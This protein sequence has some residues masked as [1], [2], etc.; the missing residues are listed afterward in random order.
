MQTNCQQCTF[1]PRVS[2]VLLAQGSVSL[3]SNE[4]PNPPHNSASTILAAAYTSFGITY[5]LFTTTCGVSCS[6]HIK[7]ARINA[8]HKQATLGDCPDDARE[9]STPFE[10]SVL[11]AW[12]SYKGTP[13]LTA[14]RRFLALLRDIDVRLL[15]VKAYQNAPWGFP[16]TS[17]G[18][19]ICPYSN[20]K[21]GCPRPLIDKYGRS[22]EHEIDHNE[23]LTDFVK[24]K[25]WLDEVATQQRCSLGLHTSITAYM[26]AR[27]ATF[28]GRPECG[29]FHPH[30]S[31]GLHKI[32][33]KV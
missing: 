30:S 9:W 8:V 4:P 26:G 21:K 1:V 16:T 15:Q 11:S 18:E 2:V 27:F 3:F 23:S 7:Q 5:L 19:Q 13:T 20:A 25:K 12:R 33:K 28:F 6:F 14:K 29:G 24:L 17:K 22:L 10:K 32:V 31:T